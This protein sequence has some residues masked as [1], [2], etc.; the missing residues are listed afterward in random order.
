MTVEGEVRTAGTETESGQGFLRELAWL[1][2]GFVLPCGSLTFYRR[3]ARRKVGLAILFFALFAFVVSVLFT[4]GVGGDLASASSEIREAFETGEIP[5]I[6]IEDGVA[7][8]EAEQPLIL[9]DEQG[10]IVVIDTTGEMEELNPSTHDQGFLLTRTSLHVMSADGSYQEIPLSELQAMFNANPLVIDGGSVA[11]AWSSFS[12]ILAVLVFA[13]VLGWNLL[14]DL[15]YVAL[16]ALVIWGVVSLLRSGTGFRPILIAGLYA[17]VPATY[18]HYLLGLLGIRF[19]TLQSLLLL[20]MWAIA[21]AVASMQKDGGLLRGERPIRLWRALIGLPALI[22]LALSV[23]G[24]FEPGTA[25]A[26][27]VPWA[28]SVVSLLG[29]VAAGLLTAR[30]ATVPGAGMGAPPETI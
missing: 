22:A 8:V 13:F 17:L 29:L 27:A 9:V 25:V 7:S 23:A 10:M 21:L 20:P 26:W 30:P 6:V 14:V 5:V 11:G 4:V 3:A 19:L 18:L 2:A 12:G 1:G 28:A 24:A 16:V 15:A